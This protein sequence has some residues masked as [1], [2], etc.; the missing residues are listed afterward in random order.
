MVGLAVAVVFF[1]KPNLTLFALLFLGNNVGEEEAPA[2]AW[3]AGGLG[4][5]AEERCALLT[6]PASGRKGASLRTHVDL[7]PTSHYTH[8][9]KEHC[10]TTVPWKGSPPAGRPPPPTRPTPTG[11][12]SPVE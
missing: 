12:P 3:N 10:R 11:W 8:R 4:H 6:W 9:T 7:I 2:A 1:S 5:D